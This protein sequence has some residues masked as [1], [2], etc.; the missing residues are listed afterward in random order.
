V[1][2][3]NLPLTGEAPAVRWVAAAPAEP[4]WLTLRSLA[5]GWSAAPCTV[6]VCENPTVVEAAADRWGT[7][8]APLVCTDGL[9]TLA[10]I[11]LVSGLVAAGCRVAVRADVDDAG[12]VVVD[13]IRSMAP[14]A[15]PWRF[16]VET[17]ARQVGVDNNAELDNNAEPAEPIEPSDR[18]GRLRELYAACRLPLHEESLLELLVQD[19]GAEWGEGPSGPTGQSA[20]G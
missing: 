8:C 7:R 17:Y 20:P 16:D 19:L 12:F 15:T 5:G 10:A 4:V 14:A 18:W 3:L 9:A 1:L 13:Q 6:F 11:D 2:T